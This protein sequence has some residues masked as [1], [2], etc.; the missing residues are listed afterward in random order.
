MIYFE[1]KEVKQKSR[2][3]NFL[4]YHSDLKEFYTNKIHPLIERIT[5]TKMNLFKEKINWKNAKGKGFKAHQDHPAWIDFPPKL[6][7]SLALFANLSTLN[8]GCLEFAIPKNN[9]KLTEICEYE[10]SLTGEIKKEIV[11]EFVWKKV[12]TTPR[13]V[14]IFDSYVPHRSGDNNTTNSRRIF[15]FTFNDASD[16]DFYDAYLIKKREEFP[17]EIERINRPINILNN[18]YNLGNPLE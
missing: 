16:G 3:E 17:P 9:Q 1:R 4:E 8:N 11:D 7:V 10:K 14:L 15:Y 13:D 12:E 6:Y 2:L 18:K 5:E